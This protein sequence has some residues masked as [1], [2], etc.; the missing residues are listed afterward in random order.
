AEFEASL[1]TRSRPLLTGS[2]SH[3][4]SPVAPSGLL[5]GDGGRLAAP[6]TRSSDVDLALLGP[7]PRPVAT[8]PA[9]TVQRR[10]AGG[11]VRLDGPPAGLP[12]V[13]AVP[14]DAPTPP[15][16][17]PADLGQAAG[18]PDAAPP[19]PE[20]SPDAGPEDV[21]AGPIAP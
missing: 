1:P 14:V 11:L 6:T 19:L 13:R 12:P 16:V 21:L 18:V 7:A 2:M 17:G 8:R 9:A 20:P 15:A 4:V 5:D 10:A 3:A